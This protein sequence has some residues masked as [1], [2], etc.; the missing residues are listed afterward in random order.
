MPIE[1]LH[2]PPFKPEEIRVIRVALEHLESIETNDPRI[3]ALVV[4]NWP[5]LLSKLQADRLL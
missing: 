2:G 4:R 1:F 5:H 3:R